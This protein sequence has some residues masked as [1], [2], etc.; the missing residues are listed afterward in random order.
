M[1]TPE[2]DFARF[3]RV[4]GKGKQ[5]ARSLDYEEA[6]TAFRMI[7]AGAVEPVQ[8]G[9]FLMLLRVKEE[10]PAELAGFVA[11]CR[12][13]FEAPKQAIQIDL[14]WSSY[15]GKRAQ[16]PWFLLSALLLASKG[17]RVCM[18]GGDGH[19]PGRLY[20]EAALSQLGIPAARSM[21]ELTDQLEAD[22]FAFLPLRLL[23]PA[24]D[25]IMQLKPLLGLRSPVN[26][27]TRLLNPLAAKYSIQSV[28]HPA[29]A[30]L[31]QG[32]ETLLEQPHSLVFKGE[33]GEV[34]IRPHATSQCLLQR[35]G[36]QQLLEWPRSIDK[37]PEPEASL[38][39][40]ALVS[41]W[42]G[43]ATHDYG[44]KAVVHTTALALLLLE[45]AA[46]IEA[47]LALAQSWWNQR[48][49]DRF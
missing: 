26:T 44:E 31:H 47:S 33:G 49:R 48:N 19:T 25:N 21:G 15:A 8:L 40:A 16:Q 28:F 32:A 24:L 11:A 42:R 14:D 5:G 41:L 9:A 38:E 20:A 17:L 27:L 35:A 36:T 34:E 39:V 46:D 6:Y 7:L 45:H 29:Y 37:K 22:N 1:N 10:T 3:V 18:H 4:L 12:D 13:T 23:C 43:D 30:E 2:H